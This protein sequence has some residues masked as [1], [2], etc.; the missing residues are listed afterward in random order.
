MW[1]STWTWRTAV[2]KVQLGANA[3]KEW[4]HWR[5]TWS[6]QRE[7]SVGP[8]IS[9]CL[10]PTPFGLPIRGGGEGRGVREATN[11][12]GIVE[13]ENNEGS[14]AGRRKCTV[15]TV[16]CWL[17]FKMVFGVISGGNCCP[18]THQNFTCCVQVL[19]LIEMHWWRLSQKFVTN[20]L[21]NF[22]IISFNFQ[23]IQIIF[24]GRPEGF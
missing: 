13:L 21:H 17:L 20:V 16:R 12:W 8:N 22:L 14:R 3:T 19:L 24:S 1:P 6:L 2:R 11:E 9:S 4:T 23:M 18:W 7:G 15:P 5:K 10:P